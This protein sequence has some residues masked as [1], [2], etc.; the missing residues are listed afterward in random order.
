MVTVYVWC[1]WW[2]IT[3]RSGVSQGW[4]VWYV[5][6]V[7]FVSGFSLVCGIPFSIYLLFL[8]P[9]IN[10]FYVFATDN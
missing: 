3:F 6:V 2:P 4:C 10:I 8:Y 5:K 1:A 9:L 7:F